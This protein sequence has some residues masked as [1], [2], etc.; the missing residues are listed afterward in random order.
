MV[1]FV[2]TFIDCRLPSVG[3]LYRQVREERRQGRRAAQTPFGFTLAGTVA[4]ER[5]EFEQEEITLF[6]ELLTSSRACVDIG[7]NIG[8]YACLAA[9][10]NKHVVAVEPL[11]TNLSLLCRN[12]FSNGFLDVEVYPVGLSSRPGLKRLYGGGT[13]ASF[14]A[15]WAKTPE[16][17][18]RI[19]P[20]TTL[21]VVLGDRFNGT[22]LVIKIDVEGFE[23]EVLNGA[24]RTLTMS[25]P[26]YWLVEI[27]FS[28][29]YATGVNQ[30]FLETFEIFW[31]HKYEARCADS[32]RRVIARDDVARW[33]Q[34]GRVD[35]GSHNYVF[36]TAPHENS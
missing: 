24:G 14:V 27:C 23:L 8:L 18:S 1:S 33:V 35:F 36:C 25:P 15:G 10:R 28:E 34:N 31:Q 2:K 16:A 4:M 19:V 22:Q 29:H 11:S 26:P 6:Q 12:L 7:A 21:D 9:S 20:V 17:W 5:G 32:G 3:R 30:H 13:G